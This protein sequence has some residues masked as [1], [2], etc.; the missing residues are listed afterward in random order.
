[1]RRPLLAIAPLTLVL[2]A[3]L[4]AQ[5]K[6]PPYT[7]E[8]LPNGTVL[9]LTQ[10]SG[11]PLVNFRI[12]VKGGTE[13]ETA[14][15]AGLSG[16]T[17][18]LLRQGTAR[19]T[20]PQFSEELDS[21]GGIFGAMNDAEATVINAEF[22]RKDFDA[23]L[24]LVADAVLHPTFP[25]PEVRKMLARRADA[26]KTT[27]DNPAGAINS[28]FHAFYFGAGHA[29]GHMPDE[30]S[31][32]RIRRSDIVDYYKRLYVGSNLVVIVA[33][34]FDPAMAKA[35]VAEV[36]GAVPGGTAYAW[37]QDHP[38]APDTA[39]R[40]LLVDKPDATQTYFVIAQAG[41]PHASP[42]RVPLLLVNTLFG[43]RFTSMVNEALRINSGLTYG[44]S[45]RLESARMTGALYIS[46]YTKTET[47]GQAIDMALDVLKR[48]R[49]KGISAEQLTSVKAY[50]KGTYPTRTLQT[51]DEIATQL[52]EM[53]LYGLG[54]DEVDQFFA[55]VDAVTVEQAN[56]VIRKYY[57]ADHPTFVL[58]GNAAKIRDAAAKYGKVTER[59]ARQ[60]GWGS[61]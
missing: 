17:A 1:M 9:Y 36:F 29:Y 30:A 31:L 22:L 48:L 59:A 25:E 57:A 52:G 55:R 37:A 7:R 28:F 18:A 53:E 35:R 42:D 27:K 40:V 47:T 21:L 49:E 58:L 45:S 15:L 23:G 14:P 5:V 44:A 50:T 39:S 20:A 6:L 32:D 38:P 46:S 33:G 43:G 34:D 8:V 19:W 56:Q 16:I 2:C 54:R 13:S 61:N 4:P 60:P 41:A 12:L 11:L 51:S 26:L 24:S 10:R 3:P